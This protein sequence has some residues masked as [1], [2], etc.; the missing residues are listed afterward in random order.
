MAGTTRAPRGCARIRQTSG[1]GD[2]SS[3]GDEGDSLSEGGGTSRDQPPVRRR[4]EPLG[5]E[6]EDH[7]MESQEVMDPQV[8]EYIY[9]DEDHLEEEDPRTT[10]RMTT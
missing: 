10:R 3:P 2:G 7:Q 9:P 5:E 4:S 1:G 6:Q 8:V